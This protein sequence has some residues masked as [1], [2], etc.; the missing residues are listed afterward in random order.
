MINKS[1]T[2][3]GATINPNILSW[4]VSKA[5][6]SKYGPLNN[7]V[8][9]GQGA[10]VAGSTT[11]G[12]DTDYIVG[13]G[14]AIAG[15]TYRRDSTHFE[16]NYNSALTWLAGKWY[17]AIGNN[18][19]KISAGFVPQL[20]YATNGNKRYLIAPTGY[21]EYRWGYSINS[22]IAGANTNTFTTEDCYSGIKCF[23]K[24]S[25]GNWHISATTWVHCYA[26]N[27][28]AAEEPAGNEDGL[29]A[30]SAY[31]NPFLDEFQIEF[32]VQEDGSHVQLELVDVAG[33]VLKTIVDNPHSKGRWKYQSGKLDAGTQTLFCRL[34]VNDL[35]T[36]K[37]L[38]QGN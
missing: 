19:N 12:P 30:L 7:A 4:I 33:R 14:G 15:I 16:E 22:P 26:S 10:V 1:R 2:D 28:I 34:K 9:T 20:T 24:D 38:I 17:D 25:K 35:Y 23:I 5:T 18:G 13:S 27:R 32:D 8:R 6:I 11:G 31:P 21:A 37:K 3:F 36:I 29:L